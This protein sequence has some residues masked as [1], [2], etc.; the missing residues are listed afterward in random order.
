[1]L[2]LIRR[3]SFAASRRFV[4]WNVLGIV[5]FIVA[6]SMGT[7]CSGAFP[8]INGLIGN[9]T[10]SAMPQLPLVL[11][12]AYMVPFFSMLHFTALFQARRLA[13]SERAA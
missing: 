11:I 4:I 7:L 8:G 1:M 6:M 3:P 2:R 10:T 13:H 9:L 12:P 5:D